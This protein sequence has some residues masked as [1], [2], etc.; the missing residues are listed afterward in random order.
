[1]APCTPWGTAHLHREGHPSLTLTG[2]PARLLTELA[3]VGTAAAWADLARALWRDEPERD[4]LRRRFDTVLGRL[5]RQ[6]RGAGIRPDLIKPD[7]AG[8]FSLVLLPQDR[9]DDRS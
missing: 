2:H 5:W 1:M 4:R 7:G 6:L 3:G 8:N 9:V